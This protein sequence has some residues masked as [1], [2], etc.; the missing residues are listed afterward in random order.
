[1]LKDL[2]Q[3]RPWISNTQIALLQSIASKWQ[4][5]SQTITQGG[6]VAFLV[7]ASGSLLLLYFFLDTA[8]YVILVCDAALHLLAVRVASYYLVLRDSSMW[9]D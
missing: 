4:V 6:A 5:E 1:M 7:I 2:C 8:F 3:T 9:E